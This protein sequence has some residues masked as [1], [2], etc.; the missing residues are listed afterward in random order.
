MTPT[1]RLSIITPSSRQA[2]FLEYS[3]HSQRWRVWQSFDP[4]VS[5]GTY[6]DLYPTGLA[7]RVTIGPDGSVNNITRLVAPH[8]FE[9]KFIR[10]DTP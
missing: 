1:R 4:S 2:P 8:E 10:R 3:I 6:I 7:E 5:A 9:Y